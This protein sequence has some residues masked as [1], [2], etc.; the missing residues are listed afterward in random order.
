M[1]THFVYYNDSIVTLN[2]VNYCSETAATPDAHVCVPFPKIV[3]LSEDY[4]LCFVSRLVS[5]NVI[6]LSWK[7]DECIKLPTKFVNW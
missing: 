3:E 7:L 2:E 6:N 4:V 5:W 1:D